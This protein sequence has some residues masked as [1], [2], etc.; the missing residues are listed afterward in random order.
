VL[1][2]VDACPVFH[3]RQA[4]IDHVS[5]EIVGHPV[6]CRWAY[7]RR[8]HELLMQCSGRRC[9]V[10]VRVAVSDGGQAYRILGLRRGNTRDLTEAY[11]THRPE[12]EVFTQVRRLVFGYVF[13]VRIVE[14]QGCY[15]YM[16]V[17]GYG[18]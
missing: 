12:C 10:S 1:E 18:F 11:C 13:Y 8:G 14:W 9:E 16:G 2:D 15:G 4:A 17:D 3:E 6:T 5:R 7:H